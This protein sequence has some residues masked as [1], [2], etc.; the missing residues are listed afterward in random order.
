MKRKI[1]LD[2][3]LAL[4][5]LLI[6]AI[7]AVL[8]S[9]TG[10]A[11]LSVPSTYDTGPNGYA[12]LYELLARQGVNVTRYEAAYGDLP[13]GAALAVAGDY[14]IDRIAASA[15]ALDGLRSWVAAGHMLFV[16][17]ET[18]PGA[19]RALRI[20]DVQSLGT[21]RPQASTACAF[22]PSRRGLRV[23]SQFASGYARGC[24]AS[25]AAVLR[26]G[27]VAPAIEY[28]LGRGSVFVSTTP[29]IFDNLDLPRAQNARVAYD[30][31]SRAPGLAFDERPYGYA[32]GRSFWEVLGWPVRVAAAIALLAVLLAA[33]G[34]NVPF[35]P[36]Y[37][38]P[39]AG[40]RDTSAYIASLASMLERAGAAR[41]IV[42]RLCARSEQVLVRR[43]GVDERAAQLRRRAGELARISD[44]AQAD[45]VAAG[46]LFAAVRK[47]YGW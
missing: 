12:A 46:E 38:E 42:G 39:D 43:A 33:V 29:E 11:R 36:P 14:A 17:G 25:R 23:V 15:N 31:F 2:G 1:S 37:E 19:R 45:V 20:P 40:G 22:I 44:P 6:I 21:A 4:A 28:S 27:G 18:S 7:L 9:S 13:H 34:A 24:S 5:G 16:L 30:V 8:R 10:T 47:E 26:T 3:A 41:E 32:R 35:A